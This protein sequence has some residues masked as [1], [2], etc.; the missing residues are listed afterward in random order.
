LASVES[1]VSSYLEW[2]HTLSKEEIKLLSHLSLQWD[3]EKGEAVLKLARAVGQQAS[4]KGVAS[5]RTSQMSDTLKEV[6]VLI[7]M[8]VEGYPIPRADLEQAAEKMRQALA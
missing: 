2:W 3:R 5:Q 8:M 1:T 7:E 4:T 6:L